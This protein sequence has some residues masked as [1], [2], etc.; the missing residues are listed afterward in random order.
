MRYELGQTIEAHKDYEASSQC[1]VCGKDLK[2]SDKE[3]RVALTNNQTLILAEDLN[4][5]DYGSD[6]SPRVGNSCVKRFP[7]GCVFEE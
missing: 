5:L 6:W 2:E 3:L 4:A 7:V 1:Y